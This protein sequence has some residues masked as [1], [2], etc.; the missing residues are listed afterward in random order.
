MPKRK[1]IDVETTK[2]NTNE[3]ISELKSIRKHLNYTENGMR[4]AGNYKMLLAILLWL[5]GL[6]SLYRRNGKLK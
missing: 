5:Y 6:I 2:R 1:H 3:K 4:L